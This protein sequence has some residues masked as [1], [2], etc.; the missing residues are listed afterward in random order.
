MAVKG[1]CTGIKQRVN[2]DQRRMYG[3]IKQCKKGVRGR[4]YKE[5][6]IAIKW[7]CLRV[8]RWSMSN[9]KW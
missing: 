2:G 4:Y 7:G 5:R 8:K 9:Q 1:G 6:C 3:I